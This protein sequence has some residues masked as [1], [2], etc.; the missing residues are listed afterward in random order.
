MIDLLALFKNTSAYRMVVGDKKA[1]RLS[2]A[3][4]LLTADEDNL[5]EYLKIFAELLACNQEEPCGECRACRLIGQKIHPDVIT[6]PKKDKTVSSEEINQL[7][8][9]SFIRPIE[10]DKKIFVIENIDLS[11]EQAQNKML[12]IIEE[13]PNNVFFLISASNENK[14]LKTILSRVQKIYVDKIDK[15]IL[16]NL[17]KILFITMI[18]LVFAL[19]EKLANNLI[20]LLQEIIN[21]GVIPISKFI[22]TVLIT[23]LCYIYFKK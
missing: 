5:Q 4:L 20:Y 9:E 6:Y 11:T 10:C 15:K 8:E 7:I 12:K 22:N 14:V 16:N 21:L 19:S 17:K 13:P 1:N 3:Y 2:H 18:I 23:I